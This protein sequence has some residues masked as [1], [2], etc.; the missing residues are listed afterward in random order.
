MMV[1]VFAFALIRKIPASFCD[2]NTVT[3]RLIVLRS[4]NN[5]N[6]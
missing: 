2:N 6:M 5:N 3:S 4:C 1:S